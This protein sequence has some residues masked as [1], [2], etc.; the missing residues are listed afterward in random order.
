MLPVGLWCLN[1]KVYFIPIIILTLFVLETTLVHF[2]IN[3]DNY[4]NTDVFVTNGPFTIIMTWHQMTQW[5]NRKLNFIKFVCPLKIKSKLVCH[6]KLHKFR[7]TKFSSCKY[8]ALTSYAFICTIVRLIHRYI[9]SI[10]YKTFKRK[11]I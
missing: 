11:C 10:L 6:V 8:D 7:N 3:I 4:D 1:K 2:V 9:N 5:K